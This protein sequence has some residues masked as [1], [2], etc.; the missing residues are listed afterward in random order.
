MEHYLIHSSNGSKTWLKIV[1]RIIAN[2]CIT[3]LWLRY[4]LRLLFM[5][6]LVANTCGI[7]KGFYKGKDGIGKFGGENENCLERIKGRMDFMFPVISE[8]WQDVN[9]VAVK[10]DCNDFPAFTQF[11]PMAKEDGEI[12]FIYIDPPYNQHPYGSN[13][14]MLNLLADKDEKYRSWDKDQFSKVSGIPKDWNRSDYNNRLKAKERLN[15]LI[16]NLKTRYICLSYSSDGFISYDEVMEI[17]KN[18]NKE[19]EPTAID[20]ERFKGSRNFDKD[21]KVTEYLFLAH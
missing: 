5:L 16:A 2:G 13:Y 18:N 1:V 4:C 8:H 6:I 9:T 14:F 3:F 7:F 12:D 10:M 15:H 17:F 11:L 20:Y 21:K 19:V